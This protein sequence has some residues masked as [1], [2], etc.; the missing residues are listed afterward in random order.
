[1]SHLS[2]APG[3]SDVAVAVA[4]ERDPFLR[5]AWRRWAVVG[6][7]LVLAA[8]GIGLSDLGGAGTP[9]NGAQ[10]LLAVQVSPVQLL[11]G[12]VAPRKF[13]GKVEA[14]RESSMSFE[15]D[16]K[17]VAIEVDEGRSVRRDEVIALLDTARLQAQRKV[18]EARQSSAR[19][20]L[21]E[22]LTGP[23]AEVIAAA[24]AE[25]ARLRSALTLAERNAGRARK[26]INGR[27]I[28]EETLDDAV[29]GEAA[30]SAALGSQQARLDELLAGTRAEQI[31]AQRAAVEQIAAEL[32]S[33]QVDLEKS[34]LRAT[35][36]GTIARRYLD[37]GEVVAAGA[38]VVDL[39]ES[40]RPRVRLGL[41]RQ[42]AE[43]LAVDDMVS[44]SIE[45]VNQ[46]A[47][48]VAKRPDR[49]STTRTVTLLLE[50][51]GPGAEIR[52]GDLATLEVSQSISTPG[53]WLPTSALTEGARGLWACYVATPAKAIDEPGIYQLDRRPLVLIDSATDRA[54][55][56]GPVE[57]DALFVMQGVQ[58][59]V[60]GQIV[61]IAKS[62]D[63]P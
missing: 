56:Q 49:D 34:Q 5:P 32:N 48:V 25:L 18:L 23:R 26:L 63:G 39:I 61:R 7:I 28:S 16:G 62:E 19:A 1:M 57:N 2:P 15:L 6:S 27:A 13:V 53:F 29:L 54:Y 41:T 36:D 46:P 58:R 38:P 21:Q 20:L 55:V 9:P 24:R 35:F 8:V 52:I 30:A 37:E 10:R 44:V 50:L 42:A 22:L 14:N 60:P 33:I 40:A 4:R 59:L 45:N 17:L 47:R 43:S 11:E 51:T 12:Y 31:D 3:S